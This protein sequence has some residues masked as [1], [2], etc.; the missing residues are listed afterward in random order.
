VFILNQGKKALNRCLERLDDSIIQSMKN[1]TLPQILV[2]QAA[3]F[4]DSEIAIREKAYG[5]WQCYTWKDYHRNVM[6]TCLGLMSLNLERKDHV[7]I[8]MNN[9]S[10]WLFSELGAQAAGA[11]TL[12]LFTSSI[13]EELASALI[14][15]KASFAIVQDQ[16]QVDKLLEK[17]QQLSF[18]KKVIYI[19]PTG[20]RTY[21]D[22]PWLLSFKDLLKLGEDAASSDPERF[23]GELAKG[24]SNE[25]ALMIQTSGTTGIPKLAM[26]THRNFFAM[27]KNW[28]E[29][30]PVGIGSNWLS[31]TP[32][33]WIVDQMLGMGVT[34]LGGMTINFPETPETVKQDFREIGP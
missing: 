6:L 14:R 30:A 27:A 8:I 34:L 29:A 17:R 11:V 7:G 32:P 4:G 33:A 12:N 16:E 22:N 28:L 19:D 25:T 10:E 2:A 5:L 1:F 3:R 26:L 20:M 31:M 9:H 24:K 15:A 13:A 21:E 18:L 23:P